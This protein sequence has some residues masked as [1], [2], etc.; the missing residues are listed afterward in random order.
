[1]LKL[2]PW[3]ITIAWMALIFNFSQAQFSSDVTKQ[4]F[5]DMNFGLRK[6]GHVSEYAILMILLVWSART[7]WPRTT[8]L[9]RAL[10]CW[11]FCVMYAGTDEWHQ[12]YVHGR[13]AAV[14]DV[15]L[16]ASGALIGYLLLK[17]FNALFRTRLV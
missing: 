8:W 1:M 2:L 7:T 10:C 9:A 5:G 4:Y 12:S 6:L 3:T 14:A 13:S 17:L 15:M 11:V 16:D